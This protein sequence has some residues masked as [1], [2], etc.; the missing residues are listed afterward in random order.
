MAV[1]QEQR[2]ETQRECELGSSVGDKKWGMCGE[3]RKDGG[4][5]AVQGGAVWLPLCAKAAR[6]LPR[7]RLKLPYARKHLV[8][9]V[10]GCLGRD[11]SFS[12]QCTSS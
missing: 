1:M 11:N 7:L 5:C 6:A 3:R 2:D 12:L 10:P 9:W 4:G 8:L